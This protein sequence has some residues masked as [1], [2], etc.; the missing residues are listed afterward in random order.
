[1]QN[2]WNLKNVSKMA[3]MNIHTL[4]CVHFHSGKCLS[5]LD[6]SLFTWIHVINAT[7]Y[8][9][10]WKTKPGIFFLKY[11]FGPL[12]LF[13]FLTHKQC[14]LS[15]KHTTALL[16]DIFPQFIWSTQNASGKVYVNS[17]SDLSREGR[18]EERFANLIQ[19]EGCNANTCM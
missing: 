13:I 1:M 3:L 17:W 16:C 18:L 2:L 12:P 7:A 9:K 11:I 8:K 6:V 19:G 4:N 5:S 10:H 14:I 15:Q